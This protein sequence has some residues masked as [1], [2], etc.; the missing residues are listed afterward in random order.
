MM[1]ETETKT[2]HN[3]CEDIRKATE[4]K[5]I[6]AILSPLRGVNTFSRGIDDERQV[7]IVPDGEEADP[8]LLAPPKDKRRR[9]KPPSGNVKGNY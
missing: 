8:E 6:H 2:M 5:I 3:S 4:R 9:R 7:V 1:L